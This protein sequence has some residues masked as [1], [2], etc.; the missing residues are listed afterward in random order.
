MNTPTRII[1]FGICSGL[2]WSLAPG[3]LGGFSEEDSWAATII[4]SVTTG[5]FISFALALPLRKS[6]HGLTFL[7]GV[8][9]LPVA[10]FLDGFLQTIADGSGSPF[11]IGLVFAWFS[12]GTMF[13]FIFV[14]CAILTTFLF[15][16]WLLK[17]K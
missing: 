1:V 7:L 16:K 15:R 17:S 8:L 3:A 2:A 10:A 6:N 5:I 14:P 4:V 12:I 13:G 9:S 11:W